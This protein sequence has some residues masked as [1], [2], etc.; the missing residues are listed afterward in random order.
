MCDNKMIRGRT[1]LSPVHTSN[2]VEAT[3][4]FVAKN[5][6]N[7]E[8]VYRKI[9]SFRRSRNKLNMFNL[10]RLCRKNRSTCSIRHCC[11]CG[12]GLYVNWLL[13]HL[14]SSRAA[15]RRRWRRRWSTRT[16]PSVGKLG[17]SASGVR[18]CRQHYEWWASN[19]RVLSRRCWGSTPCNRTR[20]PS[21][22]S[23]TVRGRD[24][25]HRRPP[26]TTH[27]HRRVN[28]RANCET[29]TTHCMWNVQW[30]LTKGKVKESIY[31]APFIYY[32]YLKALRHGSHSFT[33]KYSMPAFP[34]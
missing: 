27:R 21:S 17:A 33:C 28:H 32:V 11:W 14:F 24:A 12:R 22:R 25:T 31:I 6:N 2:I 19:G 7:V 30:D 9:S 26:P 5:G 13:G 10:F 20:P 34:S 8:R 15:G 1:A 3:F 23:R 4:D 29:S 16:R 18:G